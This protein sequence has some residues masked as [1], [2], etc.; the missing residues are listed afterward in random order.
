MLKNFIHY[1]IFPYTFIVITLSLIPVPNLKI[2]D[3]NL[4]QPDKLVH[5][6]MYFTMFFGWVNSKF[7]NESKLKLKSL[8][9]VFIIS[10]FTEILQITSFIQR[11]FEIADLVANSIGIIL[12]YIVFVLYPHKKSLS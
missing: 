3:F 4:F 8:I 11:H 12:S 6:L 10:F 5:M 2:P 1:W 9:L 7:F